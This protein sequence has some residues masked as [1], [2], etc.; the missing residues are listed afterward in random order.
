MHIATLVEEPDLRIVATLVVLV[1]DMHRHMEVF[2][3]VNRNRSANRLSSMDR[4]RSFSVALEFVDLIHDATLGGSSAGK[5]G[6]VTGS[7]S[8]TST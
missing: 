8:G 6:V 5:P 4:L 7:S 3:A 1:A 2:D